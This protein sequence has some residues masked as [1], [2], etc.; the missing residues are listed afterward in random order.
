STSSPSAGC[1]PR[2]CRR[3]TT[4]G[5]YQGRFPRH[6]GA[7]LFV[8]QGGRERKIGVIRFRGVMGVIGIMGEGLQL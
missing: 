3:D 8:L 1:P 2:R 7:A 4:E 5:F 6:G